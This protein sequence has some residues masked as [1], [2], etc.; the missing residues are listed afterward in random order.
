MGDF[1]KATAYAFQSWRE[2]EEGHRIWSSIAAET[3]A[4]NYSGIKDCRRDAEGSDPEAK[5]IWEQY[6]AALIAQKLLGNST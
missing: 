3:Y 6:Q 5:R 4:R 2:L 1:I